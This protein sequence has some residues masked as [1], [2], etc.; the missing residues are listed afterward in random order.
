MFECG[1]WPEEIMQVKPAT[2]REVQY[3][4]RELHRAATPYF[5]DSTISGMPVAVA[6]MRTLEGWQ[7]V[8]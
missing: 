4:G 8:Q 5:V 6:R 1:P 2:T 3:V 7:L